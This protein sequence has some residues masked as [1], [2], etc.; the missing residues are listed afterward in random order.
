MKLQI[1]M[2]KYVSAQHACHNHP[3]TQTFTQTTTS[4]IPHDNST[5]PFTQQKNKIN[6]TYRVHNNPT[7][8]KKKMRAP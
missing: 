1:S 2:V 8:E 6:P 3:A 7:P 5:N 4:F